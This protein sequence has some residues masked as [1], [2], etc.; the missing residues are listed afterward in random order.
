[1]KHVLGRRQVVHYALLQAK[2]LHMEVDRCSTP[3][4][5]WSVFEE[6][7]E[8][9][10]FGTEPEIEDPVRIEL[11]YDGSKPWVLYASRVE[12]SEADWQRIAECF[13]PACM[14][15][16]AKWSDQ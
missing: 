9:V 2:I 1:M 15:A 8:R 3:E 7:L 11:K 13:R 5:F 6:T 4:E 16:A 12:G 10:G 14:R